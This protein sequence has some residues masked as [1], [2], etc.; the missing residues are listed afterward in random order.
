MDLF[1]N[2]SR[3]DIMYWGLIITFSILYA[4]TAFVSWYHAISFFNIANPVWL[5]VILSFVA[6]IGQAAVLF[7]ILLTNNKQKFLSWAIMIILTSLQIIGN[8]VSSYKFIETSNNLDFQFFQDSI[9]FWVVGV[10][11][12]MFKII[13]AWITGSLLPIIALG[14]TSLVSQNIQ[15]KEAEDE[16]VE[17]EY[18]E[19]YEEEEEETNFWGRPK[20]KKKEEAIE[21]EEKNPNNNEINVIIDDG[22]ISEEA[23]F[24]TLEDEGKM[25]EI[26]EPLIE[27]T[28]DI[29]GVKEKEPEP[30]IKEKVPDIPKKEKELPKEEKVE[31]PE[32]VK[33][34]VKKKTT[35]RKSTKKKPIKV[36]EA[37]VKKV[38]D[39]EELEQKQKQTKSD[40]LVQTLLEIEPLTSSKKSEKSEKPKETRD[41]VEV[42][43]VKAIPK[44]DKGEIDKWGIPKNPGEGNNYDK[45]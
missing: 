43:D 45:Y 17:E 12:K 5:S 6:E 33:T 28:K 1:K 22:G 40:E 9:L 29:S 14:M 31:V 20:K 21:E 27:E 11:G 32:Q 42:I 15:L 37:K 13:I 39:L 16:E 36:N 34:P 19:E 23:P 2:K 35:K 24:P 26:I 8:V 30:E 3:K 44:H 18:E 7:S 38:K 4:A 25:T 41:G 10:E